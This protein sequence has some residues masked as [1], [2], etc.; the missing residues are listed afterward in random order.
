MRVLP[1]EF[2]R[3]TFELLGA[4][5]MPMDLTEAIAMI[6]AGTLDAQKTRSPIR[7]PMACTISTNSTR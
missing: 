2:Q 3:R 4:V 6:K 5:A 1:S 7:S